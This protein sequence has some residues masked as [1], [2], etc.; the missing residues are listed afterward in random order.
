MLQILNSLRLT[1]WL[2]NFVNHFFG[3][4][5]AWNDCDK[6][7]NITC[8]FVIDGVIHWTYIL[9]HQPGQPGFALILPLVD[10]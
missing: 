1:P 7:H 9:K 10:G 8:L 5:T 4:Y 2:L 6:H 3:L